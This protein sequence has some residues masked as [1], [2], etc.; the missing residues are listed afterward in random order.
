MFYRQIFLL[1]CLIVAVFIVL[2]GCAVKSVTEET[3]N[4]QGYIGLLQS[5]PTEAPD[6]QNH[7][8]SEAVNNNQNT[9]ANN[10]SQPLLLT[11]FLPDREMTKVFQGGFE[12]SGMVHVVDKVTDQKVQIKQIDFGGPIAKVYEVANEEI[13]LVYVLIFADLTNGAD[14]LA[15]DFTS[16]PANRNETQLK[17]PIQVGTSWGGEKGEPIS[18]ITQVDVPVNT[19]AGFFRAIEVTIQWGGSPLIKY[20]GKGVGIIKASTHGYGYELVGLF[21][22]TDDEKYLESGGIMAKYADYFDK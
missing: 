19:P 15:G 18:T 9:S 11:D 13:V 2:I 5:A 16:E 6:A 4:D 20:F 17:G 10:Q 14:N 8:A 12:N 3:G 1:S 22:K 7:L 21:Y